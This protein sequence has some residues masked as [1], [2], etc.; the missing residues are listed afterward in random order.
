[1]L[2]CEVLP[3]LLENGGDVGRLDSHKDDVAA[4]G[5]LQRDVH[6]S[7]WTQDSARCRL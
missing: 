6:M 2:V 5:H 1:M 3:D 4:L 7:S